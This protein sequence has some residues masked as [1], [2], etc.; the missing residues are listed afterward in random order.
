MSVWT[1]TGHDLLPKT[2]SKCSQMDFP[3]LSHVNERKQGSASQGLHCD[4]ED[5]STFNSLIEGNLQEF[6]PDSYLPASVRDDNPHLGYILNSGWA[7]AFSLTYERM[8]DNAL[9]YTF[10]SEATLPNLT[11]SWCQLCLMSF[12][13][14]TTTSWK[15]LKIKGARCSQRSKIP[16]IYC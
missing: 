11:I 2:N 6:G 13:F 5:C 8:S 16:T 12:L 15:V 4:S 9:R 10:D 7:S 1:K 3:S 14:C